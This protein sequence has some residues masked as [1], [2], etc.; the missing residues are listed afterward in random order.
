MSSPEIFNFATRAHPDLFYAAP[1]SSES[2]NENLAMEVPLHALMQHPL[3]EQPQYI[4][5]S[6]D[7][8]IPSAAT[9]SLY[10]PALEMAGSTMSSHGGLSGMTCEE[11]DLMLACSSHVSPLSPVL[12][13][14]GSP[15]EL[16]LGRDVRKCDHRSNN[17]DS[18]NEAESDSSMVLGNHCTL[19]QHLTGQPPPYPP[20]TTPGWYEM[21]T[22]EG[23]IILVPVSYNRNTME[24]P[25]SRPSS[26]YHYSHHRR[27]S[28]AEI[29]G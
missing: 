12:L 10:Y 17:A 5:E 26:H 13:G 21:V 1:L 4:V 11:Q 6:D 8:W 22:S 14:G 7:Q 9:R 25:T 16:R 20:P 23:E 29:R 2:M 27:S 15:S 19:P 28:P 24:S 18:H 3:I